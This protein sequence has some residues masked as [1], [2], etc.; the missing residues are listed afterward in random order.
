MYL[1][2]CFTT[3]LYTIIIIIINIPGG[4]IIDQ[5]DIPLVFGRFFFCGKSKIYWT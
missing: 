5:S 1:G 2:D 4:I 3:L